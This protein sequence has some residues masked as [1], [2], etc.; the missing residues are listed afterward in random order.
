M[1][2]SAR[3]RSKSGYYHVL[4]RG[5][6]RQ[7]IFEDD[8]DRERFI[9]TLQRYKEEMNFEIHAY[10]LMGNHVHILIK[11][12]EDKLDLILKKIQCS[13]AY[14]F[15]WKYERIGHLFQDRF[16]SEAI[17]DDDYYLAVLR[18][19]HQN[20]EKAGISYAAEYKWSSY[21]EYVLDERIT[22]TE[23]AL[24][25][26]GGREKYIEYMNGNGETNCL[27]IA[28]AM[29]LTDEKAIEIIKKKCK[30]KSGQA[31]QE[32]EVEKRNKALRKLKEEGLSI[33]QI[34]RLTGINRGIVLKA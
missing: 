33:R 17:E 8:E 25:L 6:G 12:N 23:F 28:E 27:E 26:L 30:V 7:N 4:V 15:N 34:S 31:L 29:R 20:P 14:Y 2:R 5:I 3:Q 16:K 10:C 21:S 9:D 22:D 24:E 32:F 19:I 1:P 11:D 18:Y 13:Y